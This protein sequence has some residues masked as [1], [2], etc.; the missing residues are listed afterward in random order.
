MKKTIPIALVFSFI[1]A[2]TAQMPVLAEDTATTTSNLNPPVPMLT[3]FNSEETSSS[4][5]PVPMLI[6][7]NPESGIASGTPRI[8]P[9]D[10]APRPNNA[11]ST[12]VIGK[13]LE[14]IPKPEYV[15]YFNEIRKI[16]NDLF[17]IRKPQTEIIKLSTGSASSTLV[18]TSGTS[19]LQRIPSPE[20]INLFEKIVKIGQD[21]F[22]VKKNNSE[23]KATGTPATSTLE[24]IASPEQIKL[25]DQIKK[26]GN[27]LFGLRKKSAYVLP[28]MTP[29][30]VT[31]TS[32]A[33]DV[34]DV[35][36][37]ASL[38]S[39]ASEISSAIS[40]RGTCQK[41]AL[42]LSSNQQ[43][44]LN[45]CNKTFQD[46][47]KKANDKARNSQKEIWTTYS[48]SLKTCAQT[49][50][51]TEIRIEDGGQNVMEPLK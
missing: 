17:G 5:A 8:E 31:C 43:T 19:T 30:L 7:A 18:T 27:D 42:A 23:N 38:T 2:M 1:F 6:S 9:R 51:V 14:K 32:A 50:S 47:Q 12:L 41:A 28:T 20:H 24:R 26:I 46:T 29:N 25:F 21:L 11:S 39:A 37:S 15:K 34:K 22:G 45:A 13:N 49:A 44:A 33:I 10:G 3:S 4:T 35:A 36:I 40:A 48:N 16:G